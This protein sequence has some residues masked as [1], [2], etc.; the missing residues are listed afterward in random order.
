VPVVCDHT[1]EQDI[2]VLFE[3]IAKEQNGQLDVLV[4]NAYGGV[5]VRHVLY[6]IYCSAYVATGC[7]T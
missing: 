3:Q 2:K 6:R 5:K 1:N 7:L 4:N